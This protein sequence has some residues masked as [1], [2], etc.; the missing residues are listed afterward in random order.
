M[1]HVGK[2]T[3]NSL[4][5]LINL[6]CKHKTP[7]QQNKVFLCAPPPPPP[8]EN[9]DN[10]LNNHNDHCQAKMTSWPF[11]WKHTPH[12]SNIMLITD[13]LDGVMHFVSC[14]WPTMPHVWSIYMYLYLYMYLNNLLKCQLH[15]PNTLNNLSVDNKTCLIVYRQIVYML[16]V[17]LCTYMC[18]C[19]HYKCTCV[20]DA[21]TINLSRNLWSMKSMYMYL[22]MYIVYVHILFRLDFS[23]VLFILNANLKD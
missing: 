23:S 10:K 14:Y 19:I 2:Q 3:K 1:F 12:N 4:I 6:N 21:V 20:H 7:R 5:N 9:L 15:T 22:Y 13:K 18:T 16:Y 17:Q 8:H 11:D